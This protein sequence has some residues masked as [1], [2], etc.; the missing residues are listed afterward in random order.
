[1]EVKNSA[2]IMGF[3]FSHADPP[4]VMTSKSENCSYQTQK[5]TTASN[6]VCLSIKHRLETIGNFMCSVEEKE[7]KKMCPST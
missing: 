7:N 6:E 5:I 3:I 4:K 1:M 2:R